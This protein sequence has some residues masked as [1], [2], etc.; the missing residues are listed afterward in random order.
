MLNISEIEINI[1]SSSSSKRQE[2]TRTLASQPV[3]GSVWPS[4]SSRLVQSANGSGTGSSSL[5]S[6]HLFM[7]FLLGLN[8]VGKKSMRLEMKP[9]KNRRFQ[10]F[11]LFS[12]CYFLWLASLVIKS[13]LTSFPS[14][15]HVNFKVN[16]W[17]VT[18]KKRKRKMWIR[19]FC[20]EWINQAKRKFMSCWRYAWLW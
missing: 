10:S 13:L 18:Q 1:W 17:N 5:I 12:R 8:D 6:A 2:T 20:L 4:Y 11:N 15:C 9:L 7:S 14:N 3:S 19:C 16:F